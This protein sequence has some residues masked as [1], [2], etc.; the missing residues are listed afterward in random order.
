M[1]TLFHI[2]KETNCN[3]IMQ[4]CNVWL[5]FFFVFL[6]PRNICSGWNQYK[7]RK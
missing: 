2:L 3:E 4:G 6:S 1:D 7:C 5:L